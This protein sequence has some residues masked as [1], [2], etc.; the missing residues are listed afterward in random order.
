MALTPE[1][2]WVNGYNRGMQ[3][4]AEGIAR[5][6]IE[7]AANRAAASATNATAQRYTNHYEAIIAKKNEALTDAY[8]AIDSYKRLVVAEENEKA[9]TA[10]VKY[11]EIEG[12]KLAAEDTIANLEFEVDRLQTLLDRNTT[13]LA[14][15]LTIKIAELQ[16]MSD[17]A[18]ANKVSSYHYKLDKEGLLKAIDKKIVDKKFADDIKYEG[19]GSYAVIAR[20]TDVRN[21]YPLFKTHPLWDAAREGYHELENASQ[22]DLPATIK[23]K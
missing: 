6:N 4:F 21:G 12:I 2:E 7:T 19:L 3:P 18:H 22:G 23:G 8:A 13:R 11:Y 9:S 16:A 14:K 15:E 1:E 20:R 5:D 10:K 17:E